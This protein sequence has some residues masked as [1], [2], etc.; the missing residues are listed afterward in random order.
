MAK[1][2]D[3]IKKV[4]PHD[5]EVV[6]VCEQCG[7]TKKINTVKYEKLKKPLRIKCGCGSQFLVSI[8][9][10]KYYRKSTR[11]YGEY[12][13]VGTEGVAG[14]M[15]I[16]NLSRTGLGFEMA[17]DHAL[18]PDD[19]LRIRFTLDDRMRTEIHKKVVVRNMQDRF[20]GAEFCDLEPYES[21]LGF[22][23][24]NG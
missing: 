13:K 2:R 22:Y 16:R 4:Y 5:H 19:I 20:V 18:R 8:E 14:R 7:N 3:A 23:L 6:L 17:G 15:I 9:T 11:L 10:R 21:V 12:A 1:I 24:M